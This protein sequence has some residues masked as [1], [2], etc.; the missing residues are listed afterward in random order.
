MK[1]I[2]LKP[3]MLAVLL[4]CSSS[5]FAQDVTID[6]SFSYFGV[7]VGYM[8]IDNMEDGGSANIGFTSGFRFND[9]FAIEM[10]LDYH[11][12][13]FSDVDR[14]TYALQ[15][16][17][18]VYLAPATARVQPYFLG[19]GGFYLSGYDYWTDSGYRRTDFTSHKFGGHLG[20]G[21]DFWPTPEVSLTVD[22]RYLFLQEDTPNDAAADINGSIDGVLATI[23]AKFRF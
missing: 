8:E 5:G 13:E 4:L 15:A 19:G 6:Q 16:S 1:R 3:L 18:L 7:R 23:G 21:I 20:A 9:P 11:T 22:V 12:S 10:S 2:P 17:L 14:T